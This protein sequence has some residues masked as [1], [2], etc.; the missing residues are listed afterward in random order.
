M[1]TGV[2]VEDGDACSTGDDCGSGICFLPPGACVAE[3][4]S[5]CNLTGFPTCPAG[6][7]CVPDPGVSSGA[8][9]ELLAVPDSCQSDDVCTAVNATAFCVDAEQDLHQLVGPLN[10]RQGGEQLLTAKG[11]CLEDVGPSCAAP[12]DCPPGLLC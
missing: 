8:C 9:Y 5:A 7:F 4:G 12:E 1:G 3:E 6:S 2:G 11:L 10:R